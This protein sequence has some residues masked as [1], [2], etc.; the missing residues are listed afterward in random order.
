MAVSMSLGSDSCELQK[1]WPRL[2]VCG[3][4]PDYRALGDREKEVS[5]LQFPRPSD[6]GTGVWSASLPEGT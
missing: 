5:K 4:V 6:M 2:G 3:C 1:A